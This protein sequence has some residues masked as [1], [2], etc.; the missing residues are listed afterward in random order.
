MQL[1]SSMLHLQADAISD[2]VLARCFIESQN[3]VKTMAM[4]HEKLY[5]S[6]DLT[7]INFGDY[8]RT[9]T[10]SFLRS[11][12]MGNVVPA[13]EAEEMFLGVNLAIPCGLIVN[14]LIS[15]TLKYA[16]PSGAAGSLLVRLGRMGD[17]S[18]ELVVGDNGVGLPIDVD[19]DTASSLGLELVRILV[20]QLNGTMLIKRGQGTTFVITFPDE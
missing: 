15:N 9:L 10:L 3:R 4:I 13:I 5:Q 16:F 11:Y 2:P 12:G 19:P 8:L 20:Q 14:E 7:R 17:R 1:I 6:K 18:I